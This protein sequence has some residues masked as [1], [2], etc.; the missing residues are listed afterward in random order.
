[1]IEIEELRQKQAEFENFRKKEK[2]NYDDL[3]KLR[4]QFVQKFDKINI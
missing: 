2:I 3:E 1:M 4:K